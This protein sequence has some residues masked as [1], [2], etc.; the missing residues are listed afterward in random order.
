MS[1]TEL[2]LQDRSED[3]LVAQ[4]QSLLPDGNEP[5]ATNTGRWRVATGVLLACGVAA[6]G[7]A[8][9]SR[10]HNNSLRHAGSEDIALQAPA[11]SCALIGCGMR[12]A[13]TAACQCDESCAQ[14]GSCCTDRQ[15]VCQAAGWV[16]VGN[17]YCG[18]TSMGIA[19]EQ[20]A[21]SAADC[22]AACDQR[23]GC[24][25]ITFDSSLE[26]CFLGGPNAEMGECDQNTNGYTYWKQG[27]AV[28][29]SPVAAAPAVAPV[30]TAAAAAA[31]PVGNGPLP[32]KGSWVFVGQGACGEASLGSATVPDVAA[33]QAACDSEQ[34]ASYGCQKII[35]DA[36]K[37]ICHLGGPAEPK[38]ACNTDQ[39][40]LTYWKPP[41]V[42]AKVAAV[43]PAAPGTP[44]AP[45]ATAPAMPVA[46]TPPAA[47]AAAAATA[48]AAAPAATAVAAPVAA[49]PVVAAPASP[50]QATGPRPWGAP[51]CQAGETEVFPA[52]C[53]MTPSGPPAGHAPG[54]YCSVQCQSDPDC[55]DPTAKCSM[56]QGQGVKFCQKICHA[57][58]DCPAAAG[59]EA[60]C[61]KNIVSHVCTYV[62]KTA[63]PATKTVPTPAALPP[64]APVAPA[65]AP[66]VAAPAPPPAVPAV[67]AAP[68]MAPAAPVAVPAATQP[69]GP[70]PFGAP[71]CK[72][73]ET[74]VKPKNCAASPTGPPAGQAPGAYCS[75][76]CTSDD[77]CGLDMKCMMNQ[78]QG[79]MYCQKYCES[80][81]DCD[82]G[83]VG[84]K[85]VCEKNIV[86][87]VCSYVQEL[88]SP[89]QAL[90]K[91]Q[92]GNAKAAHNGEDCYYKC[93]SQAG[94]CSWCGLSGTVGNVCC[95]QGWGGQPDECAQIPKHA[96]TTASYHQCVVPTK[97]PK[98]GDYAPQVGAHLD[99]E[100]KHGTVVW[101]SRDVYTVQ[102]EDGT[103]SGLQRISVSADGPEPTK[104]SWPDTVK[105]FGP[106]DN[107]QTIEMLIK[108]AYGQ[109]GGYD[110]RGQFVES[111]F[112]FLFRPG[113]YDVNVPVGYYTQ[114][115]GL[116]D[117]PSDVTFTSKKGVYSEEGSLYYKIGALNTFWRSAE[118][119]HT[120]ANWMWL[121]EDITHN[122]TRS[123]TEWGNGMLWAVSQ[124]APLR[125]VII[126]H[127][128]VLTEGANGDGGSGAPG[129]ASGGY[130]GNVQVDGEV[131]MG[132]QQQW[133]A[134]NAKVAKWSS[135]NWNTVFVGTD[136]APA[137]TC[138]LE[139][140]PRWSYVNVD[141]TPV[142]AEKPYL[143]TDIA[144]NFFLNIPQVKEN[145]KGV[146]FSQPARKVSFDQV[147]VATPADSAAKL[148]DKL[149]KGRHIVLTPGI[150]NMDRPLLVNIED[151]VILG[152]GLATLK[153]TNGNI[154]IT[155]G[156]VNGVRIGGVLLEAGPKPSP[157]LLQWGFNK[158]D[159][160]AQN[161][162]FLYDVFGRSGGETKNAAT[163]VMLE[164][165]SGHVVGDNV[166]LWRA[167]HGAGYQTR[168]LENPSMNGAVITGNDVTM[169][170]LFAEHHL[171]DQV[172][173][174]GD[175][176][177]VYFLQME[178][179]YDATASYG[180]NGYAGLRVNNTVHDFT[181][182]GVGVY[183][184]FR[185]NEVNLQS[186]I[187][188]PQGMESKLVSPLTLCLG[189]KGVMKH[190]VN[191]LGKETSQEMN[192]L[193]GFKPEYLNC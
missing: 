1:S 153:S 68:V 148:N 17:G 109:N 193:S 70:R 25:K 150:Y 57:D 190:V 128:L 191:S 65:T 46:A 122:P 91:A 159:G 152:L 169:Y 151:Q 95:R 12:N 5:A 98:A 138:S 154:L 30:A 35:F 133:L 6:A 161:P 173:W 157:A 93:S 27:A 142:I 97:I 19:D 48:A 125:R 81:S 141:Q 45:A 87:Q 115:L 123:S 21:L 10:P 185:D 114:V 7:F 52:K 69:T 47:A 174:A 163:R 134:R 117:Q 74:L 53:S 79:Q 51:Q 66:V 176:G 29:A 160:N 180:L 41:T 116:G 36:S 75:A 139:T 158:F 3:E 26:S 106:E 82:A 137:S 33:C 15:T 99:V 146:D 28:A 164:I 140:R 80:V 67:P 18:S 102:F 188:V 186:G 131:V 2:R 104:P 4:T 168:N 120:K 85:A 166:W 143:T 113:S 73:G 192:A 24:N 172:Q 23:Q 145:T 72:L 84:W 171:Q 147:Y 129:R 54:S 88:P 90:P 108:D 49:A 182:V 60:K 31:A 135:A 32:Q 11:A 170:G 78:G 37:G 34:G 103:L 121:K 13:P 124:A 20:K 127:D 56:N 155:V 61:A 149:Q 175:R 107:V 184:Y 38:G 76:G 183:H 111:R 178:L 42:A 119:F 43:A 167:D 64:A 165:R 105:V 58:G 44:V 126:D 144:G 62:S 63:P 8:A 100:G 71:P 14:S 55:H 101:A 177:A 39:N 156:N 83:P 50:P 136:G 189:G 181:G 179:P 110:D 112:A 132:T 16:F 94:F 92:A 187:V 130:I 89:A 162:G 118:N 77:E 59:Y 40:S 96:F 9:S 22:Q 86:S